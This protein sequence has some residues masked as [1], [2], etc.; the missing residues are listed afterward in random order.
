MKTPFLTKK[1]QIGDLGEGIAVRY[2]RS[3]GFRILE[4]NFWKP[5]GEIDIVAQNKGKIHFIEVKSIS[6]ETGQGVSAP[7]VRPEENMHP[8]K[9]LRLERTIQTYLLERKI[10]QD[11]EW[12]LDLFCVFLDFQAKKAKVSLFENVF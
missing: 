3:K 5:W 2:L 6:R 12:Q 10:P 1:R 11:G 7:M 8:K 9:L 4:Q